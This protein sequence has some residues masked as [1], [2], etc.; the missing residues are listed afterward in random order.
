M[1]LSRACVPL[2]IAAFFS[3]SCS[4]DYSDA[5]DKEPPQPEIVLDE[6]VASRFSSARLSVAFSAERLEL[7]DADS[8]WA[9]KNITFTQ[10]SEDGTGTVEAEGKAGFMLVDNA[11]EIYSLGDSVVF[12]VK[13]EGMLFDAP[14]LRWEKKTNWLYAPKDGLVTI[15]RDDGTTIQGTGFIADTLGWRYEMNQS[16]EG[17]MQQA[18][19]Q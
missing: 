13:S 12:N 9:G 8:I 3:L 11:N 19:D 15:S 2:C 17:T 16:A 5:A 14:D 18:A 10:F 7:Y 6:A 1:K 4:F